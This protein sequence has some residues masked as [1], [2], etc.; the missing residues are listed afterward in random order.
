MYNMPI[1]VY[2]SEIIAG[3]GADNAGLAKGSIITEIDGS[4]VNNME[5][6]KNQLSYYKIGEKVTVKVQ[7][8]GNNGDYTE[9]EYTITLGE[10]S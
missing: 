3:G 10:N 2:V 9:K 5:T 1:G 7:V 8:P 6:L 4:A